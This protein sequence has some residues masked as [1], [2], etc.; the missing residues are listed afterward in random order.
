MAGRGEVSHRIMDPPKLK[1]V[2][3]GAV[4]HSGILLSAVIR[5][6]CFPY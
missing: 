1:I 3:V 5:R 4:K 6:F 2:V